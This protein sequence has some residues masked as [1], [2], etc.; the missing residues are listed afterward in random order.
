MVSRS[1]EHFQSFNASAGPDDLSS[2]HVGQAASH[3]IGASGERPNSSRLQLI[4]APASP[5]ILSESGGVA[6]R[7]WLPNAKL[8][9][10]ADN[11]GAAGAAGNYSGYSGYSSGSAPAMVAYL[12]PPQYDEHGDNI[13]CAVIDPAADFALWS[14][15]LT[16]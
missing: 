7:T 15:R 6:H 11:T 2:G 5:D 9:L 8:Q 10:G 4:P 1:D 13:G 3:S 16:G 14:W 12:P